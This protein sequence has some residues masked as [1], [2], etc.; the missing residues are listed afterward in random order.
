MRAAVT[1]LLL[2]ALTAAPAAQGTPFS[3]PDFG[4]TMELPPGL[5]P[6]D[7][8]ARA[9]VLGNPELARNV[10]R[11]QAGG[12]PLR[13][14]HFWSDAGSPYNRQVAIY[15]L[16]LPPP[17][18]PD[19][20]AASL[21]QEGLQLVAQEMLKAQSAWLVEGTFLR[22]TDQVRLHKYALYLPD[23][24]GKRHGLVTLQAFD[25]DWG[26]VKSEFRAALESVR[27]ERAAPPAEMQQQAAGGGGP[28]KPG[29]R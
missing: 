16:D 18:K 5:Q 7:E 22:P 12:Q 20:F 1:T 2:A 17:F 21:E 14:Y 28:G 27:M 11:E 23:L 6:A 26:I 24:F 9:R 13:H 15:L 8:A 25:S 4:F 19:D 3:D 10:P 29:P